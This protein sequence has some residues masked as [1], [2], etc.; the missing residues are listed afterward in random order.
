MNAMPL[1]ATPHDRVV[2]TVTVDPKAGAEQ[3]EWGRS[4]LRLIERENPLIGEFKQQVTDFLKANPASSFSMG[5]DASAKTGHGLIV[6][7][8]VERC[9]EPGGLE[10]VGAGAFREFH[11]AVQVLDEASGQSLASGYTRRSHQASMLQA[12]RA[13]RDLAAL[14][15]E[16]AEDVALALVEMEGHQWS[17]QKFIEAGGARRK[18]LLSF[19]TRSRQGVSRLKLK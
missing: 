18:N 11:L 7:L 17:A 19:L 9:Y 5:E 10:K 15:Q 6:K 4:A 14:Q 16:A 8:H 12:G 1:S 13:I 3:E 2:L